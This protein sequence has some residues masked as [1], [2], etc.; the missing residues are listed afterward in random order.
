MYGYKR[1]WYE[2]IPEWA[3]I[4]FLGL[5][6]AA[7]IASVVFM[8]S[9]TEECYRSNIEAVTGG[10]VHSFE[11]VWFTN[12]CGYDEDSDTAVN[13]TLSW[14]DGSKQKVKL[15]CNLSECY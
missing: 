10:T 15:C 12:R 11:T 1:S 14:P 4:P 9:C 7:I 5:I 6:G 8:R 3:Q 2:K 13:A